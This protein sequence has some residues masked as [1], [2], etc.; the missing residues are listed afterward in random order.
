[1]LQYHVGVFVRRRKWLPHWRLC[2]QCVGRSLD[3]F[4]PG[5]H[6]LLP[7]GCPRNLPPT[8]ASERRS[9]VP[10]GSGSHCFGELTNYLMRRHTH[11]PPITLLSPLNTFVRLLTTTSAYGRTLTFRKLPTV[12]SMTTTKSY[13]SA[14]SRM[15]RKSGDLRSGFPGNSVNKARYVSPLSSLFSRSSRSSEDPN[16]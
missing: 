4:A 1:M 2:A 12:S 11:L 14:S 5:K 8:F 3:Y 15:R 7:S 16:P 9:T 6:C 10:W 13:L